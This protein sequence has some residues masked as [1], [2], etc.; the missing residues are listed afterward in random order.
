M[1]HILVLISLRMLSFIYFIIERKLQFS[2]PPSKIITRAA[3]FCD[4]DAAVINENMGRCCVDA[5]LIAP[6]SKGAGVYSTRIAG[7][8]VVAG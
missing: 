1:T 5:L 8:A 6:A 2:I 3:H 4:S 7:G